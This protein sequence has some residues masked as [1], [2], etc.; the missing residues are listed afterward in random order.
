MK[1]LL[2]KHF[3]IHLLLTLLLFFVSVYVKYYWQNICIGGG[4]SYNLMDKILD[5]LYY[6]SLSLLTFFTFFL[7]LPFD[8]FKQWLKWIFS[9]G[10]VV[11]FALVQ[12]T[13]VDGNG[14]I[15]LFAREVIIMLAV[16]FWGITLLFCGFLWW[17]RR[18]II[19]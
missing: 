3:L 5:P 15:P 17:R 8:Y 2:N 16:S 4:C 13:I 19:Q 7:F 10:I 14:S 1:K 6:A 12:A 18:R 11:S 9:W